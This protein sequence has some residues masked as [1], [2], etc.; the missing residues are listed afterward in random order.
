MATVSIPDRIFLALTTLA[1]NIPIAK[2]V[3]AVAIALQRNGL[4]IP[5]SINRLMMNGVTGTNPAMRNA[6]N[7]S[8]ADLL[9]SGPSS[10]R[11]CSSWSIVSTQTFLS[12][13]ITSTTCSN[14]S[15]SNP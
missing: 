15:P 14:S 2:K 6:R 8:H 11:L 10:D 4:G 5:L 7:V 12:E 9:G 13:V 1:L 3:I